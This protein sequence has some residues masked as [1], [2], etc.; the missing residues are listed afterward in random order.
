MCDWQQQ[1]HNL[2]RLASRLPSRLLARLAQRELRRYGENRFLLDGDAFWMDAQYEQ[3]ARR[4]QRLGSV[5]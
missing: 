2:M 3:Y 1:R 4:H 5:I